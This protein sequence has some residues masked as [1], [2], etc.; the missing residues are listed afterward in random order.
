MSTLEAAHHLPLQ[1]RVL[2]ADEPGFSRTALA[3]VL[4]ETPGIDVVEVDRR[5]LRDELRRFRPD[6]LVID[7]RLLRNRHRLPAAAGVR[8]IVV[9]VDDDPAYAMRAADVGAAAWLPKERADLLIQ[10][11]FDGRRAVAKY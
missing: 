10:A 4:S 1:T 5:G 3:R 8:A 6:V 2:L 9:G 7:D 11:I